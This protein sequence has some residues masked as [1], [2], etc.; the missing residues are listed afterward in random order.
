M[1]SVTQPTQPHRLSSVLVAEPTVTRTTEDDGRERLTLNWPESW[2]D[3]CLFSRD[4][5]IEQVDNL[6]R[7]TAWKRDALSSLNDWHELERLIPEE[8][9]YAKLGWTWPQVIAAY[10]AHLE[11]CS[12]TSPQHPPPIPANA[13]ESL[14]A[15]PSHAESM[16]GSSAL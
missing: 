7:L 11:A 13:V 14:I 8:F 9:S 16:D 5:L 2:P 10:I 3:V 12:T 1:T 4:L 6:N 15:D